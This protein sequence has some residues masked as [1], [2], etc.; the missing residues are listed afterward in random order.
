MGTLEETVTMT[1]VIQ[2]SAETLRKR[3]LYSRLWAGAVILWSVSRTI[4]VWAALSG[5]GF[6]PWIYLCLDLFC[7]T[8]DAFTTPRMVLSFIDDRYY[9]AAK[10]G[11]ISLIAFIAPDIY[12]FE[13][14]RTL[15]K[16]VVIVLCLVIATMSTIA[17]VTV[18]RKIRKGRAERAL[19]EAVVAVHGHA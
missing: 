16:K 15:P 17:V 3:Q 5:Y 18:V 8:I 13:G 4:I 6:N 7:S 19:A 1:V 2:H 9:S 12:I 10:W 14:T 11:I